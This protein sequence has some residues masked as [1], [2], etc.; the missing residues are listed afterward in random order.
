MKKYV[1]M[2]AGLF[3]VET[4][5]VNG[6]LTKR[7]ED[8]FA[9]KA[10]TINGEAV[11]AQ[12][13]LPQRDGF[14]TGKIA[15]FLAHA[16][17]VLNP[18]GEEDGGAMA[19]GSGKLTAGEVVMYTPYYL[20][21]GYFM[22]NAVAVIAN[23]DEPIDVGLVVEISYAR[24]CNIPVIGIRTDLRT[25]LGKPSEILSI[26]P[27]VVEQCDC[28]LW[29]ETPRGNFSDVLAATDK[30]YEETDKQ[31]RKLI[32]LADKGNEMRRSA[33]P[34]FKN[35]VEGSDFLFSNL[36]GDFHSKDNMTKIVK[37]F[38]EHKDFLR[39]IAPQLI[40]VGKPGQ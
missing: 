16:K 26:N 24:L 2:A 7:L 1:Y 30:I 8:G 27:F 31:L 38:D 9:E 11:D 14:E 35:I 13:Y 40:S 5:M 29:A 22:S 34:I 10:L 25:P 19:A 39:E 3:N 21:L 12:C 23:L 17:T 4:N 6:Y 36:K 20:D 18:D 37:N 15:S 28:F 32:D 33:N